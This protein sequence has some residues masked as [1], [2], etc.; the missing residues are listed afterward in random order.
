MK[1]RRMLAVIFSAV[2]LF[3]FCSPVNAASNID[4]IDYGDLERRVI[5]K[6]E[7]PEG[8]VPRVINSEEELQNYLNRLQEEKR[9]MDAEYRAAILAAAKREGVGEESLHITR[10][11]VQST[12]KYKDFKQCGGL[13]YVRVRA[14]FTYVT[15]ANKVKRVKS[16]KSVTS[17]NHG[18]TADSKWTQNSASTKKLD[19]SRTLAVTVRG[20]MAHYLLVKGIIEVYSE[21][22]SLYAEFRP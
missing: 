4:G 12:S 21:E 16:V 22:L 15:D 17:S 20:K 18:M 2:V 6:A 3:T 8:V 5:S 1:L 9:Q 13:H 11:S 7:V 10:A 14:D 19:D